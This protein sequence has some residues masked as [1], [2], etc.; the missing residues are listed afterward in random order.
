ML[1]RL[2][3]ALNMLLIA[4]VF[5][6]QGEAQKSANKLTTQQLLD[7]IWIEKRL[8]KVGIKKLIADY[9]DRKEPNVSIVR[10]ALVLSRSILEKHPDALRNQ[11]QG[12]LVSYKEAALKPFQILPSNGVQ[13]ALQTPTMFQSG[14]PRFHLFQPSCGPRKFTPGATGF[15]SVG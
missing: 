14:H 2:T 1:F 6:A 15:T 11:L 3:F 4:L 9:K 10:D 12:R 7:P 5:N 8:A 13:I